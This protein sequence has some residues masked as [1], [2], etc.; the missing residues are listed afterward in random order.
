M[1]TVTMLD[2]PHDSGKCSVAF[3]F[4]SQ[5]P[6]PSQLACLFGQEGSK[7]SAAQDDHLDRLLGLQRSAT[8]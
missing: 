8:V 5:T 7:I 4:A 6:P 1:E 3:R 2:N